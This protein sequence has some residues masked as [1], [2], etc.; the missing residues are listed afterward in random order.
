VFRIAQERLGIKSSHH[1]V[2]QQA[3]RLRVT[4]A[5]VYQLLETCG[6]VLAVRW[7]EGEALI[8]RLDQKLSGFPSARSQ[9]AQLRR[10]TA[11]VYPSLAPASHIAE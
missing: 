2:Q 6:D 7:P 5:R 4:R 8:G 9:V 3:R 1:S 11:I 10:L